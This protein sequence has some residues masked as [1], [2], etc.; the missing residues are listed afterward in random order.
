MGGVWSMS[1]EWLLHM[2][3]TVEIREVI[4]KH[5]NQNFLFSD[6]LV[7]VVF[8]LLIAAVITLGV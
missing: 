2:Y 7:T 6:F 4:M 3:I 1:L 8:L 5:M